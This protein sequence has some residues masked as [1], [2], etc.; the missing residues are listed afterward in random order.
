MPGAK[1]MR[2]ELRMLRKESMKPVSRM[3]M[4]DCAAEIER[5]KGKRESTPAVASMPVDKA[6]KKMMAKIAD[7]K[8]AKE[9]EFPTAPMEAKKKS[10]AA[11]KVASGQVS[12]TSMKSSKKS[13]LEKLMAMLED[14]DE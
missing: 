9:N 10:G 7:V 4:A 2:D 11:P 3:K 5:L 6:P 13:K 8:V 14:D 1:E 12:E